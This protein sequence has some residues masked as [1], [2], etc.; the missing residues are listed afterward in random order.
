ME[1]GKDVDKAEADRLLANYYK[2]QAFVDI[3]FLNEDDKKKAALTRRLKER[4]SRKE[5]LDMKKKNKNISSFEAEQ[6]DKERKAI[7]KEQKRIESALLRLE[8]GNP[9]DAE[10]QRILDENQLD[11][12]V[13]A[14]YVSE[15]GRIKA[16]AARE[17]N[18]K[19]VRLRELE[20]NRADKNAQE[21]LMQHIAEAEGV[22]RQIEHGDIDE[23][24]KELL[25]AHTHAGHL[26]QSK[27]L[28]EEDKAKDN[29]AA[30]VESRKK[31]RIEFQKKMKQRE[32]TEVQNSLKELEDS[33][34]REDEERKMRIEEIDIGR[35]VRDAEEQAREHT[36]AARIAQ[37]ERSEAAAMQQMLRMQEK[38]H[39]DANHA[40]NKLT[41][42]L[43][44][45]EALAKERLE[46]QLE[47]RRG[48][49][50][51]VALKKAELA[52]NE[53]LRQ[54]EEERLRKEEEQLKIEDAK[55]QEDEQARKVVEAKKKSMMLRKQR[56]MEEAEE[57]AKLEGTL[58]EETEKMMAE[59]QKTENKINNLQSREKHLHEERMQ[60][61]IKAQK[62]RRKELKQARKRL[63]VEEK[64]AEE[65][66]HNMEMEEDFIKSQMKQFSEESKIAKLNIMRNVRTMRGA[67]PQMLKANAPDW[68]KPN[69]SDDGLLTLPPLS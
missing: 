36:D 7:A 2:A 33:Q 5:I 32:M 24:A 60:T 44:Q 37:H 48:K 56:M 25:K 17:I 54:I 41:L 53:R 30:K 61:R 31:K 47:E 8:V 46:K 69:K 66:Q 16:E 67:L 50:K 49:R 35:K 18:E 45:E 65:A 29:L 11:G 42:G 63:K 55:A 62:K 1:G 28:E 9:L 23:H 19:K 43:A 20:H 6:V 39:A 21:E 59:F 51:Q 4:Q 52:K 26:L 40:S 10:Q 27:L 58:D 13:Q 68:A 14:C 22:M 12:F 15:N 3:N 38:I 64:D 34:R 57:K